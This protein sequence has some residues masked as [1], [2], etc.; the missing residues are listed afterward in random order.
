M[1]YI[2]RFIIT[3]P[4]NTPASELDERLAIEEARVA[5]LAQQGHLLRVWKPLPEDGRWR[6]VGL[7]HAADDQELHTIL[8]SL[9]LFPWMEISVASLAEHPND[10]ALTRS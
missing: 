1:D 6:A 10:P 5:E 8:Q 2:V 4:E 9:P 3:V 7:Y